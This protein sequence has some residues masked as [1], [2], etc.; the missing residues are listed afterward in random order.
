M[1]LNREVW[2]DQ[3]KEG[4]YPDDSFLQKVTDYSQFVDHNRLHIA[5]AGIDP[6]VL[7][8]NTTY[9]IS[10]IGRDDEDNEIRLDKFET[11]KYHC[12][13]PRSAGVQ[14]RQTRKRYRP[15]PFDAPGKCGGESRARLRPG[16]RY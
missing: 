3:V 1:A 7:V 15:A 2:I 14:L 6:K 5:S 13:P 12:P 11:E 16:G 9:P 8:N 4:F 10:V